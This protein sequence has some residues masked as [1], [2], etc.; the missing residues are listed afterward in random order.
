MSTEG[1]DTERVSVSTYVPAYQRATW[2]DEAESMGVSRSEY[3]RLMVQAGRR[4]FDIDGTATSSDS[5]SESEAGD[6]SPRRN[7]VTEGNP[8][9][10]GDTESNPGGDALR[11]RVLDLLGSDAH[12]DWDELVAGLTDDIEERLDETLEALQVDGRVRYSG[13]HGGYT[14]VDDE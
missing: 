9:D 14:V 12:L 13:R 1:V 7:G 11:E 5:E 4:S 10:G 8:E 2:A 3:V 6:G